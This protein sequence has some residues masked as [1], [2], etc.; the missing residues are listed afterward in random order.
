[1]SAPPSSGSMTMKMSAS[2]GLIIRVIMI[3]KMTMRGTRTATRMIIW[4]AFWMF[5]T[6]VVMRVTSEDAEKRSMS[7]KEK[8]WTRKNR[9]W[10]RLRARPA[11]AVAARTPDMTPHAS[12][13]IDM[14][15]RARP[16]RRIGPMAPPVRV[17]M[18]SAIMRGRMHS[19]P[20]SPTMNSG[21]CSDG[22]RYSRRLR[23]SMRTVFTDVFYQFP[24]RTQRTLPEE[25]RAR[26][27]GSARRRGSGGAR[28]RRRGGRA[29]GP[30]RPGRRGSRSRS[31]C[32]TPRRW[33]FSL[34]A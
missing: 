14:T 33:R 1:M 10:R 15:T 20:A 12:E 7:A 29:R 2:R 17:S 5:V 13:T 22:P 25:R 8:S 30:R 26:G 9:S 19:S 32:R 34:R 23:M 21:A 6:S 28:P 3:E 11:A 31:G 18:S 27:P 4:Y 24:L 16:I